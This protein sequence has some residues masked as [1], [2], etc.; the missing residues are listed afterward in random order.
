SNLDAMLKYLGSKILPNSNSPASYLAKAAHQDALNRF[1]YPSPERE[2][3]A[4]LT[5][6]AE[7]QAIEVFA[8]NLRNL[9]LQRPMKDKVVLGV[10]PAYR[11][12]CKLCVVNEQGT[13]LQKGVI[14]PHEKFKG[15]K[16]AIE[17]L[18]LSE[19]IVKQF[20]AKY[21]VS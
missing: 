6:K 4:D 1:I 3:R 15:E 14:Y 20:I 12:G 10:D 11:T 18:P 19:K 9:L 17:R 13:V 5:S 7:D 21:Q 8:M 2:M 16:E